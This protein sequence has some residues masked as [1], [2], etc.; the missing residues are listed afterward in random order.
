MLIKATPATTIPSNTTHRWTLFFAI[1]AGE[2]DRAPTSVEAR[3]F[4]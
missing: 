4:F 3:H 1:I 2:I